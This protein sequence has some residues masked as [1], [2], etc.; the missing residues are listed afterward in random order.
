MLF[1]KKLYYIVRM[2]AKEGPLVNET[3]MFAYSWKFRDTPL[4]N[5]K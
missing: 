3:G 2:F 4:E 5:L 1:S